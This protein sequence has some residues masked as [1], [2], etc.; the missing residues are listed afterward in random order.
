MENF[1]AWLW[2]VFV[3]LVGAFIA[4]LLVVAAMFGVIQ[5]IK[6]LA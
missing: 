2:D 4:V 6:W 3:E 1:K 5:V